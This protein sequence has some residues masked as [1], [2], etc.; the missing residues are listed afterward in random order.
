MGHQRPDLA[1]QALFV[2]GQRTLLGDVEIVGEGG[3]EIGDFAGDAALSAWRGMLIAQLGHL[4]DGE[5][6]L[7]RAGVIDRHQRA[8]ESGHRHVAR[9]AST[10]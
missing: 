4:H 9:R 8:V 6:G 2:I 5:I 3:C 10:A 1:D 7:G